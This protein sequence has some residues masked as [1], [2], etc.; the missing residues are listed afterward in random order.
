MMAAGFLACLLLSTSLQ[1]LY[2]SLLTSWLP[3]ILKSQRDRQSIS[4]WIKLR[5]GPRGN[6]IWRHQGVLRNVHTGEEVAGIEGIEVV[7]LL[8]SAGDGCY[9]SKKVFC[10][11]DRSNHSQPLLAYRRQPLSPVRS[12][13][14]VRV[15]EELVTISPGNAS[16]RW[17]GGRSLQARPFTLKQVGKHLQVENT[18]SAAPRVVRTA[19]SRWISFSSPQSA[20]HG[21][22]AE[23]YTMTVPPWWAPWRQPTMSYRRFGEP[24]AW[25]SGRGCVVELT[26]T[27]CSS[28]AA[29]SAASSRRLL[30]MAE[31]EGLAGYDISAFRNG[32]DLLAGFRPWYHSLMPWRST[33]F[34]A[35]PSAANETNATPHGLSVQHYV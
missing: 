33:A 2:G 25:M 20:R 30:E 31:C 29:L 18:I 24:P 34:A 19:W 32:T 28:A 1:L 12:M 5:T 6:A 13:N 11:V 26:S 14:P 21:R 4:T 22:S 7:R 8:P 16:V 3:S 23:T 10:Y 35:A 27:R 17:P 9:L 15:M